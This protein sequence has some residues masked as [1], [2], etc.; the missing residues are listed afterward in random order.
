MKLARGNAGATTQDILTVDAAGKVSFPQQGQSLAA[1]GY[2]KLPGGL[3]IQWGS[4][5]GLT[6]GSGSITFPTPFPTACFAFNATLVPSA[7]Y[8]FVSADT[9]TTTSVQVV[10]RNS[11]ATPTLF[12]FSWIAVGY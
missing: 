9:P 3:I 5:S 4:T 12:A 11:S 7:G 2:V 10:T 8:G 6:G 1:S